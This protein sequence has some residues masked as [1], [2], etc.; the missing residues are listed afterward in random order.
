V[1]ASRLQIS[2]LSGSAGLGAAGS[3]LIITFRKTRPPIPQVLLGSGAPATPAGCPARGPRST[4][5]S[6]NQGYLIIGGR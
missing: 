1:K 4:L 2:D 6:V 3:N 5:G